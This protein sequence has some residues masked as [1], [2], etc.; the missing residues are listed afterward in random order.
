MNSFKICRN[1]IDIINFL[2]KN[3]TKQG[4]YIF[5]KNSKTRSL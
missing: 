5:Q 4:F 1:F 2:Y 3:N